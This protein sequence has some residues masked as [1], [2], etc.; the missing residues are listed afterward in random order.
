MSA[1]GEMT[2]RELVELVTEYL[3]GTL[4]ARDRVRFEQHVDECAYCGEYIEQMRLTVDA[5]GRLSPESLAPETERELL[6]A[7]RGW[8]RR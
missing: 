6:G 2:C 8:R 3:E 1:D 5:L 7:F 4:P